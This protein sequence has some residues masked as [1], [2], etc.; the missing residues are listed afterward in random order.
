MTHASTPF[1]LSD[2]LHR[3]HS[4]ESNPWARLFGPAEQ[5]YWAGTTTTWDCHHAKVSSCRPH[6][7]HFDQ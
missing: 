2:Q 6:V 1:S 3:R 5:Q 7:F 4:P